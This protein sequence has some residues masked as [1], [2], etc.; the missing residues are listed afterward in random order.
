[1]V[2]RGRLGG[3][4]GGQKEVRK[5][6]GNEVGT[7]PDFRSGAGRPEWDVPELWGGLP[8]GF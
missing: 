6:V 5:A 1:M 3:H 7:R 4:G 8:L 2:S